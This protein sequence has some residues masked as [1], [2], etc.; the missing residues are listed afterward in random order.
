MET[1]EDVDFVPAMTR[2]SNLVME[3]VN[4]KVAQLITPTPKQA[5]PAKRKP[6]PKPMF[7]NL[8]PE[9]MERGS[10]IEEFEATTQGKRR[11]LSP[12]SE[13][14]A[15]GGRGVHTKH[16]NYQARGLHLD[17]EKFSLPNGGTL[18][19]GV[20]NPMGEKILVTTT[21]TPKRSPPIRK[22]PSPLE[23]LTLQVQSMIE[24]MRAVSRSY[25]ES[26]AIMREMRESLAAGSP[27]RL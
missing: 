2:L 8:V 22:G 7:R 14:Q 1:F 16:F 15:T 23:K 21:R 5:E 17:W 6:D 12:K 18:G 20:T 3:T 11:R 26:T 4:P 19:N 10:K 25:E 24:P 9:R 27:P 13:Q